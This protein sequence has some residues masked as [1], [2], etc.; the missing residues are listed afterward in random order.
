MSDEDELW[1]M[2]SELRVPL[3][4][5][6]ALLEALGNRLGV[7]DD[8]AG[9]VRLEVWA[10]SADPERFVMITWW[11]S[12]DACTSWLRSDDH[13]RSHERVPAGPDA[14]RPVSFRRH[15]VIAR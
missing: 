7:V 8:A 15:R 2:V 13:R 6:E 14:P 11:T 4:G 10:D 3:A 5:A 9:F 1:A 12:S